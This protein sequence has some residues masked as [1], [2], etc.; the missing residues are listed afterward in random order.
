MRSARSTTISPGRHRLG[1]IGAIA[2]GTLVTVVRR[3][4]L[5]SFFRGPRHGFTPRADQ[6]VRHRTSPAAV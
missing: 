4:Y 6:A 1:R 2:V 5:S 3:G